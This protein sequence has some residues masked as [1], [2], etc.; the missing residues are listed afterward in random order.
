MP[1]GVLVLVATVRVELPAPATDAGL[2]DPVVPVGRPVTLNVTVPAK[3]PEGV[4][5]TE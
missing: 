5:V 2:K 3:P 1:A 4:T